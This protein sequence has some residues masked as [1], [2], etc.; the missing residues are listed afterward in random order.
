MLY[1]FGLD[2]SE[3]KHDICIITEDG[4]HLAAF[5]V[6]H[7]PAGLHRIEETR[8]QIGAPTEQCLVALETAYNLVVDFLW[9]HHYTLYVI[10][11]KATSRYRDR[12]RSSRSQSDKGDAAVLANIL[13]TDRHLY[14]PWLPDQPLTRR[15][16]ALVRHLDQLNR[17]TLR[18]SNQLR[19]LLIRYYPQAVSLFS[20]LAL[21]ISL[22]FIQAYP[23]PQAAQAL[24]YEDLQAFCRQ[25]HHT[26]TKYWPIIYAR[27]Q[28]AT[29][30]PDPVVVEMCHA[31][32]SLLASLA[33]PIVQARRRYLRQLNE[34]FAQHPDQ[35]VFASLPG[36]GDF[37]G[38]ALLAKFGDHRQRFPTAGVVQALAG[39][40]PVTVGSGK[41][42]VVLFRRACDKEFRHI[43][44]QF[45]MSSIDQ[46]PWAAAYFQQVRPRCDSDSHAYRCLANR[47][48][49]IIWRLWQDGKPFDEAYH[50][51]QRN[52]R[53]RPRTED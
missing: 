37:L 14:P 33:L 8:Q 20:K 17:H 16:R 5:S 28:E 21:P 13:R 39:T 44:Q 23:T 22:A 10:P 18:L 32:A 50:L 1:L 24:S 43:A 29:L 27:L 26:R 12:H 36:A 42:R 47:W 25:H 30:T 2:W 7:D 9:D 38:P 4:H 3:E 41:K 45:A 35:P 49:A 53:R 46:S 11:S 6:G 34:L 15:I 48:L 19:A 52:R 40:C 51:Q 31:Q